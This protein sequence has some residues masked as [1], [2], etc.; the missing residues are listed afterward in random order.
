[1]VVV[2][3][4]AAVSRNV[5]IFE[6]VV[7]VIADSDAHAVASAWQT[8]PFR[9]VFEGAISLLVIKTVPVVWSGL[10]RGGDFG[11]GILEG[12]AVD[13]KNVQA[14]VVIVIETYDTAA[15]GLHQIMHG[16]VRR[17]VIVVDSESGGNV[18][19]PSR[20]WLLPASRGTRLPDNGSPHE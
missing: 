11:R 18:R 4:V 14:T 7:V 1:M 16:G 19:E 5:E 17:E 12:C 8:G 10:L 13:H 15:H 6:A 20:K 9:H 2:E 3:L